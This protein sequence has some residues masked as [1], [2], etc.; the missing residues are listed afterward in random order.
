MTNRHGTPIWYEL[1]AAD[2]DAAQTFYGAVMGWT[3]ETM[4]GGLERDYRI[5]SASGEGIGGFMRT[6]D[7]AEGMPATWFF[8][9]GVDDVDAAARKVASL[10]G[11][12]DIEPMDIPGVGRFA[13]TTDPQGAHFYLMRGFSEEDSTAFA[14]EKVGHCAW[15]EL[16]T[17]DQ[18]AALDF[19]GALF[20]WRKSGSV[21]L[22]GDMGEYTF[23]KSE[24]TDLGAMMD[25]PATGTGSFWNFAF[26]VADIDKT[27][28]AIEDGGGTVRQGPTEKPSGEWVIQASDP[29]GARVMFMG[30]RKK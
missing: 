25:A 20:G 29:Q 1:I 22:G 12:V 24:G 16:V 17:A 5:A 14:P 4:P 2:P 15:N 8:Y 30:E 19:Y 21:T 11:R 7:F 27:K 13:F 9:V 18:T 3:F 26:R 10:G 6:P 28:S 23:I